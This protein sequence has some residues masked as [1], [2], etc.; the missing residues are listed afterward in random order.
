MWSR[1]KISQ[2][3]GIQY[4]IIQAPMAGGITTPALI[5]A[6]SNAGGLG[7]LGAGYMPPELLYE[8]IRDVK[9]LT[10]RPFAVNLFV[11]EQHQVTFEQMKKAQNAIQASCH[12]LGIHI[13]PVTAPYSPDFAAQMDVILSE[14]VPVFSF[15]FGLLPSR[16][17]NLLKKNQTCIIGTATTLAEA[18][19]LQEQN[20]DALVFQGAEAGGHRGSFL[21]PAEDALI[22]LFDLISSLKGQIKIPIVAAGGI[23]DGKKIHKMM[24]LGA[25]GVQ[26]G[27]AFLSC[28]ESGAYPEYKKALLDKSMG[29]T[30]L[31]RSFS[32]KLARGIA[33]KFT[34]RM[35]AY[36]DTILDYPIQNALTTTMRK[37]AS[38]LHCIDFLS[39]WAG[40][41]YM[42]SRGM[43]VNELITQLI[44]EVEQATITK[45]PMNLSNEKMI[46]ICRVYTPPKIK[47][48]IWILIDRLW[49]RGLKKETLNFDLWLKDITPSPSLRQWFHEDPKERWN[50][51]ANQYVEELK[52]KNALIEQILDMV[53]HHP[54]TLF[55]AAKDMEHNHAIILQ[56]V[57]HTWP[58]LS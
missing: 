42:L 41:Q 26:M 57:L 43:G 51:F 8:A 17:I 31:T 47:K 39:L 3:L 40:E 18:L 25:S 30:I 20:I 53:K 21:T 58:D 36:K 34:I 27:T 46:K 11:P 55:Y 28:P 23:M 16:W 12:E 48:G 32:G 4:P 54:V 22:K 49:P 13:D 50:E 44:D 7:S 35:D 5:A 10:N 6:V 33:N 14:Q 56:K 1:T 15:V 2:L 9:A 38:S 52:N 19:L 37:T 24:Q 45:M 29:E